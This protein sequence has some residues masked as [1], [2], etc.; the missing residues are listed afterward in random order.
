MSYKPQQILRQ[1][2]LCQGAGWIL[3]DSCMSVSEVDSRFIGTTETASSLASFHFLLSLA[4]EGVRSLGD[5]VYWMRF[6]EML[7]TFMSQDNK[8]PL[9]CAMPVAICARKPLL[10]VR[11]DYGLTMSLKQAQKE[12]AQ[13]EEEEEHLSILSTSGNKGMGRA[14]GVYPSPCHGDPKGKASD[15][16][17]ASPKRKGRRLRP[18]LGEWPKKKLLASMMSTVRTARLCFELLL[19]MLGLEV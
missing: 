10:R 15:T 16:P 2:A 11:K 12:L 18:L 14:G 6:I 3:D 7:K 13:R 19:F 8:D 5:A 4:R 9:V 1:F 17:S